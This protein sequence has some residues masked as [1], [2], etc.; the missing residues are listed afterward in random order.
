MGDS[1]SFMFT[2]SLAAVINGLGIVRLLSGLA[3]Y[4]RSRGKVQVTHFWIYNLLLLFQFLLHVLLWW[5]LWGVRGVDSF[6]FLNYLYLLIG[7]ILIFLGSSLLLPEFK[8]GGIDLRE[9]YFEIAR[10]YFT[11]MA[12]AWLWAIGF[13]PVL[14]GVLAP[15]APILGT[16]LIA[17]LILRSVRNERLHAVLVIGHYFVLFLLV[18]LFGMQ[19][20][21]VGRAITERLAP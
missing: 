16:Y 11:V 8:T 15:T 9:Q 1:S 18:G 13:W 2:V 19:L 10:P 4:L 6:Q 21:G 17:A 3:E 7:P 20:G 14:V 5:S 12:L